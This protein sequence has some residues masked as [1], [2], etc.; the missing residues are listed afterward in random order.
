MKKFMVKIQAANV[1][2]RV[3]GRNP[4]KSA[5]PKNLFKHGLNATRFV[6]AQDELSA[7]SQ[8][9]ELVRQELRK[10]GR[11]KKTDSPLYFI[12]EVVQVD[13]FGDKLGRGSG[14]VLSSE[15]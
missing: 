10:A 3:L 5:A 12:D 8:A 7:G 13:A 1:L 11:N 2:L 6:E 9:I 15:N 4:K 14:F